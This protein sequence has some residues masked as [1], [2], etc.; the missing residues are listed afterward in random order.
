MI[1]QW[2]ALCDNP[3]NGTVLHPIL[4]DVP[5]CRRC[6]SSLGLSLDPLPDNEEDA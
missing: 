2:F 5:T 3:A 6:A 1:C 4:G